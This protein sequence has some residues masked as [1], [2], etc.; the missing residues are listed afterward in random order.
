MDTIHFS[1]NKFINDNEH[2][3]TFIIINN[4]LTTK[5]DS[6]NGFSINL[7]EMDD[8]DV[9]FR[10]NKI[11]NIDNILYLE[12]SIGYSFDPTYIELIYDLYENKIYITSNYRL[13]SFQKEYEL[14][15]DT[16][17]ISYDK[18]WTYKNEIDDEPSI[19]QEKVIKEKY[20]II[21]E[22]SLPYYR[23]PRS[24]DGISIPRVIYN[25]F[26]V[27]SNVEAIKP[28]IIIPINHN[29]YRKLI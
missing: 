28:D 25:I 11:T 18:Y 10:A 13:L 27:F 3:N 17:M 6:I 9:I 23:F 2:V 7:S 24:K 16:Y 5:I 15:K 4:S 29:I 1:N 14:Y 20:Q 12:G 19:L 26:K 21:N 22:D 8:Y